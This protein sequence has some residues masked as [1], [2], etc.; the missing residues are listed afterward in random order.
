MFG[1]LTQK[2]KNRAQYPYQ[3][4]LLFWGVL[5][6]RASV[7]MLWPFLTIYM[8]Q[9]LGVPLTT[10]T[11][12]LT[13][14]AIAGIISTTI[15]GSVMDRFGRKRAMV[16]SL[17]ASA[18]VFI[19]MAVADTLQAWVVLLAL[20]GMVLPIFNI[21]V[22]TMVADLV[23]SG[24]RAPAYA[25]IRM[26]S[27]TGIAVGPVVGGALALISF[28]LIFLITAVVYVVLSVLVSVLIHETL[29]KQKRKRDEPAENSGYGFILRDRFFLG[30]CAAYFLVLMGYTQAFSLLPVYVSENFGLL[31]NEY[32]LLITVNAGMVVFFQYAITHFTVRYRAQPVILIGAVIYAVG[33][34]SVALGFRLPHFM[35]SMAIIT[36]GELIIN[37]TATTL[38]A[39]RAPTTMRA[40]YLGIFSLGYPVAS[41]IGPVIGGYLNDTVAPVAIWYGA[42]IMAIVGVFGFM[43]V[44]RQFSDA[45]QLECAAY[46]GGAD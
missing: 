24:Q 22:N 43:L 45:R 15:V 3:F 21:G 5:I 37:P 35:L 36:L 40:R 29:P 26:I 8:Y 13:V 41:G 38:V 4:W 42:G 10:V 19:G 14:R 6:N 17:I 9:K 30:F 34:F 18:G 33:L 1:T 11:L 27:N 12:L 16:F 44:A 20:H 2:Y 28:E 39:D 25:L 46:A 31:S 7:S 32:S 23:E